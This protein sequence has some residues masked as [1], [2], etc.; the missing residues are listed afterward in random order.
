M[1]HMH[2][3]F[4]YKSN[5]ILIKFDGFSIFSLSTKRYVMTSS[6]F[7]ACL[8]AFSWRNIFMIKLLQS[9]VFILIHRHI[10]N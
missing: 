9:D 2:H 8:G 3:Y 6:V 10:I 1:S 5:I 4:Y 7:V